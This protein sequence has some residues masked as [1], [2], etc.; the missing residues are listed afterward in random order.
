MKFD[1]KHYQQLSPLERREFLY[2][3]NLY[4]HE[5]NKLLAEE[6]KHLLAR[7]KQQAKKAYLFDKKNP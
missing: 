6:R 2:E 7:Q 3:H 1:R 4:L 5:Q